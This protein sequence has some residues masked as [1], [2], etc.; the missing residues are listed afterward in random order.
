[1]DTK[2][3][4]LI[5]ELNKK[6][7]VVSKAKEKSIASELMNAAYANVAASMIKD[8]DLTV[9]KIYMKAIEDKFFDTCLDTL[10]KGKN[11][12]AAFDNQS[13]KSW[14]KRFEATSTVTKDI[15]TKGQYKRFKLIERH[16]KLDINAT[17]TLFDPDYRPA[18]DK[19]V[20]KKRKYEKKK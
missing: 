14:S 5:A 19:V 18:G 10:F 7:F 8:P 1:M 15:E 3:K 2:T 16:I 9:R 12:R 13:P 17:K 4:A 20:I 11:K 6:G